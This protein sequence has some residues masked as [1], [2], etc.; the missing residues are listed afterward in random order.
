VGLYVDAGKLVAARALALVTASPDFKAAVYGSE[1]VPPNLKGWTKLTPVRRVKQDFSFRFSTHGR[2]Y[3]NY[4]LWI[5]ELPEGGKA[6]V[7]ELSLL[8]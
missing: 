1:T 3:R 2:K 8:R 4:L 6:K 5:S 7:Q